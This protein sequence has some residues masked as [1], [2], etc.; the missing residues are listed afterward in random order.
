MSWTC[1][2]CGEVHDEELRDIR[3]GLPDAVYELDEDE[4]RRR[5]DFGDDFGLLADAG[6]TRHF[7]RGLLHL[8]I[9]GP[10]AEFSYGVWVEVDEPGFRLL[11]E[12]WHDPDGSECGPVFGVLANE[13]KPF[14]DTLGLPIA[15]QLRD[16]RILPAAIV[17]TDDHELGRAQRESISEGDADRLA[18]T[19]LH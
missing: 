11:E 16:V 3:A 10:G 14:S 19:A 18:E 17:L 12:R 9:D 1:T 2:V 8:S 7:V 5:A 6:T 13:L 15:L 4:R